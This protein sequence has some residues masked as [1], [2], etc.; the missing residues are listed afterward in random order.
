MTWEPDSKALAFF[1]DC[2]GTSGQLDIYLSHLD[3][4]PARQLTALKGYVHEAAFSPDGSKIAFL[5]VEGA[6]RPAGALAAMKP[7]SG[8]IGEDNIEVQRVAY[9]DVAASAPTAATIATPANLHAYEFDWSPDS[10]GF[11]YIAADPPGENNWWVAKLYTQTLDSQTPK[12]VLA[13]AEVSGSLHGLQ[14]AVP[15]WSPDGK[16]LAFIGGLMSDQGSTGGDV[17]IVPSAGGQ[18][19]NLTEGRPTSPAW[20]EWSGNDYLFVSE[21][22]GGNAQLI[23]LHL[24]GDRTGEGAVTFG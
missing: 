9:A 13:P 10:K 20:V 6:T 21:L 3:G 11:A 5:Y 7:P 19:R 24:Q 15:R 12:A 4:A 18:P 17:W 2:A 22:A 14:I 1:S 23:R 8:V 16:A